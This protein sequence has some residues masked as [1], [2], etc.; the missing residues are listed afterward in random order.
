MS[1]YYQN[2]MALYGPV[3]GPYD[4]PDY[5]ADMTDRERYGEEEDDYGRNF[6]AEPWAVYDP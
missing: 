6:Y 5:V 3:N 4:D 2:S 1:L